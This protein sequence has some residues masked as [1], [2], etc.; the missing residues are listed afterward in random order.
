MWRNAVQL[1]AFFSNLAAFLFFVLA[2]NEFRSGSAAAATASM[3]MLVAIYFTLQV[4]FLFTL[5]PIGKQHR[6]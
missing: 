4:I 2:V 3:D 1:T 6:M 5:Y